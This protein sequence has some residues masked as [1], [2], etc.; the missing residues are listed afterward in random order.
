MRYYAFVMIGCFLGVFGTMVAFRS[1]MRELRELRETNAGRELRMQIC[2]GLL[3]QCVGLQAQTVEALL[4]LR[5][6]LCSVE[7]Q[8]KTC[9]YP[10]R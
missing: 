2:D 4:N 8:A 9:P 7:P 5:E 1:N 10:D 6:L 3:V